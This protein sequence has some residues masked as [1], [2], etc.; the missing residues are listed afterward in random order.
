MVWILIA[1]LALIVAVEAYFL[2]KVWVYCGNLK[3]YLDSTKPTGAVFLMKE[4]FDWLTW[5]VEQCL[6]ALNL[7]PKTNGLGG[8]VPP[9]PDP[10]FPP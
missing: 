4:K 2:Y 7:Q 6:Q 3:K 5:N 9:T 1:V 8:G 10:N